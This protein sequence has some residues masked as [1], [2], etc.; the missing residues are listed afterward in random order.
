MLGPETPPLAISQSAQERDLARALDWNVE[1]LGMHRLRSIRG[2][3]KPIWQHP[4]RRAL[5]S[6]AS[7]EEEEEEEVAAA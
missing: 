1:F 3:R 4:T 5:E 2:F 7:W 6:I